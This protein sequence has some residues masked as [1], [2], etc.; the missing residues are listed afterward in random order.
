MKSKSSFGALLAMLCVLFPALGYA[1]DDV[2]NQGDGTHNGAVVIQNHGGSPTPQPLP[3]PTPTPV[4]VN[5]TANPTASSTAQAGAQAAAQAGATGVGI[6]GGATVGNISPQQTATLSTGAVANN[7]AAY[8]GQSS[9]TLNN[10]THTGDVSAN[11]VG[12]NNTAVGGAGGAGGSGGSGGSVG[13]VN[14][15]TGP[16]SAS[17]GNV[18]GGSVTNNTRTTVA[19]EGSRTNIGPVGSTSSSGVKDAGNSR[20]DIKLGPVTSAAQGGA[21]NGSGNSDVKVDARGG[22]SS[23]TTG[24]MSQN[25][26][27]SANNQ[28]VNASGNKTDIHYDAARIPV[29]SAAP[30]L[31]PP[32]VCA[33]SSSGLGVQTQ[34]FGFNFGRSD[35]RQECWD[36]KEAT[37]CVNMAVAVVNSFGM[38]SKMA[39][40][41]VGCTVQSPTFA[42]FA[43][44]MNQSPTELAKEILASYQEDEAMQA[45]LAQAERDR[46]TLVENR[47]SLEDGKV[48]IAKLKAEGEAANSQ[49]AEMRIRAVTAEAQLRDQAAAQEKKSAAGKQVAHNRP[50]KVDCDKVCKST[51]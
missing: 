13:P 11:L 34:V 42:K 8:G 44:A 26:A 43:K 10:A 40:V 50:A 25:Q 46:R 33:T 23:S 2:V 24:A 30:V 4:I 21:V 29:A 7:S 37:E 47:A 36:S 1:N 17:V 20:N 12:G 5:N 6:G 48:A 38:R 28:G 41:A 51:K 31:L 14:M 16:S 22:A 18:G 32:V 15:S 35:S 39:I 45:K 27:T 9:S 49:I 3:A 19:V